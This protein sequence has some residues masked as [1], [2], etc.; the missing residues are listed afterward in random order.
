MAE[1]VRRRSAR[2]NLNALKSGLY[3]QRLRAL[4]NALARLPE[5]RAFFLDI[6]RRQVRHQRHAT[7]VARSAILEV[8]RA[9]P[10]P[11]NPLIAYL[12]STHPD[13][14]AAQKIQADNHTKEDNQPWL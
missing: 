2:G 3:S 11:N 10:N 5:M 9:S 7:R 4:T 12:L 8:I 13:S 1:H 14:P 6:R